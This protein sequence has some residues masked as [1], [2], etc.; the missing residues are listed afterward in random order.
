MKDT[1]F[2]TRPSVPSH[3]S[4]AGSTKLNGFTLIE[5]LVVIAIIGILAAILFPVFARAREN[6]RKSSCMSNLKQVT[7]GWLQYAQDYDERVVPYSSTTGSA[8]QAFHWPESLKPY[9]KNTQILL[10]PS[11]RAGVR[12]SYTC[13]GYLMSPATG[14][15]AT[16]NARFIGDIPLPAQSPI[17][18]DAVGWSNTYP[19][20][21]FY[22]A[23]FGGSSPTTA[24]STQ[25]RA[26]ASLT[27]D[28]G[29]LGWQG[30]NDIYGVANGSR[31]MGGANY[32]FADRHVKWLKGNAP[33]SI[34]ASFETDRPHLSVSTLNLD[35][36]GDGTVGTSTRMQ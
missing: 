25:G 33:N 12:M 2:A 6:A 3:T 23:A 27:Y 30:G 18:I 34:Q 24:T 11:N 31:H 36:N 10:C 4:R 8:G 21:A 29:K 15:S 14:G 16:N 7:L 9:L 17:Y 1:R 32:A 35:Y 26:H 13:N 5:L 22:G 20:L 19:A 28:A